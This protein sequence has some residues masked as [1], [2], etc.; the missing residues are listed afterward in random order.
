VQASGKEAMLEMHRRAAETE[1]AEM[2]GR[3][4]FETRAEDEWPIPA[5]LIRPRTRL[6]ACDRGVSYAERNQ[7]KA[8]P[9]ANND[10]GPGI[11]QNIL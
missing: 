10:F 2:I 1:R 4:G 8:A 6:Y 5:A 7:K 3:P 9:S 11:R